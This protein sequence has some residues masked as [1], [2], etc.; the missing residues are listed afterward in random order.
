MHILIVHIGCHHAQL[1]FSDVTVYEQFQPDWHCN[2]NLI[3]MYSL[4]QNVMVI[5]SCFF[6]VRI[7]FAKLLW[8][9][10]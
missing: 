9:P 7:Q 1:Q 4:I 6:V 5:H 10:I 3:G 8:I 2:F